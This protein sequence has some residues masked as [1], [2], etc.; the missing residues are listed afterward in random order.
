MSK[1]AD[2]VRE[3]FINLEYQ[4]FIAAARGE[5]ADYAEFIRRFH[6]L[7]FQYNEEITEAGGGELLDVT[8][9]GL[10]RNASDRD[11]PVK[12]FACR[13]LRVYNDFEFDGVDMEALVNGG[14]ASGDDAP[15]DPD[16]DP[17][18][19]NLLPNDDD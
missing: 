4:L 3:K 8:F 17:F 2:A 6:L 13:W 1:E 16:S 9:D 12:G 18:W 11:E 14:K 7:D 5:I 10:V 19:D 15:D